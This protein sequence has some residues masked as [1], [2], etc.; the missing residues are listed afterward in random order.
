[1][2]KNQADSWAKLSV[3]ENDVSKIAPGQKTIVYID[4]IANLQLEGSV[5]RLDD[6][7]TDTAGI[8]TYNVYINLGLIE[9]TIKAGM[10]T[11]ID[12]ETAK[13]E[14]VLLVSN[15]VI[16]NYQGVKAVQ[17]LDD[18]SGQP[19]Y[20]PIEIG[21]VGDTHTQIIKGLSVGDEIIVSQSSVSD[22]ATDSKSLFPVGSGM[23]KK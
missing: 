16:K 20:L 4:A 11:Q 13:A 19:L 3:S 22:S 17:I 1:M 10:T 9:E 14:D 15:S 12:I 5:D 21:I 18:D 2:I 6:I 23:I 7:G 8:V